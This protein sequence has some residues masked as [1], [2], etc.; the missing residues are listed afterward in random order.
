MFQC[1][2]GQF[3][4]NAIF[5]LMRLRHSVILHVFGAYQTSTVNVVDEVKIVASKRLH[6][7]H[8]NDAVIV[9]AI[10]KKARFLKERRS[11]H[12]YNKER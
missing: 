10:R 4:K 11:D 12:L 1:K 8:T 7:T 2:N 5:E 6:T 3:S 9:I